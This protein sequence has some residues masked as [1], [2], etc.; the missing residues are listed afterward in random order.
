VASGPDEVLSVV[1]DVTERKR[2]E[3]KLSESEERFRLMAENARDVI[4]RYRLESMLGYEYVSPSVQTLTGYAPE[5]FYADPNLAISLIT[6]QPAFRDVLFGGL[7]TVRALRPARN[8][9]GEILH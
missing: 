5:E 9:L 7:D 1:R 8:P 2:A 4:F 3:Q 6:C